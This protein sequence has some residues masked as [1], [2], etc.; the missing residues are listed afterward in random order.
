M[1]EHGRVPDVLPDGDGPV[2]Y[3]RARAAMAARGIDALLV[4]GEENFQYFTGGS[5]SLALHYSNTRPSV[6]ILPLER[7]PIIVTQSKHYIVAA[8]YVTDFREYVDLLQFPHEL[9]VDALEGAGLRHGRVGAELGQEQRMGIPVGAYLKV[10]AALPRVEFVDAADIVIRLRMGEVGGGAS[11][12]AEGG[13]GH[14]AGPPAALRPAHRVGHDGAGR[15]PGHAP[16]SSW[17]KAGTGPRSVHL[18][19]E[20]LPGCKN[21]FHYERPLRRGTVLA[22]DTG[23]YVWMYTVDYPRMATLGAATELQRRAHR[24][25]RDVNQRMAD[26]SGPA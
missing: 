15:R 22:V 23:A 21:Q 12:H 10:A 17:R 24:A 11:L 6:L 8:T 16:T 26:A 3:A 5:A 1:R 18:Q 25:V 2:E 20:E 4:T 13:G 19:L 14:G 9:V 7:D